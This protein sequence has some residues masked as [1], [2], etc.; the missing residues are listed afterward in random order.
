MIKL[1]SQDIAIQGSGG[2]GH[3]TK[4]VE[5]L[6]GSGEESRSLSEAFKSKHTQKLQQLKW[7]GTGTRNIKKFNATE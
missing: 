2:L 7:C 5:G 4:D 1:E 3:Q 6:Q